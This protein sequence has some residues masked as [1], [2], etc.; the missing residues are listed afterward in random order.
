M[1][2]DA[3]SDFPGTILAISHDRYFINRFAERVMVM[4]E[5]GM[6]EYIGDFD[7]YLE[8]RDRPAPPPELPEGA[9][10]TSIARER[11]RDRQQSARLRELKAAVA[12]AEEAIAASERRVSELEGQ[13]ADPAVYGDQPRLVELTRAYQREQDGQEALYDALDRAEQA[14]AAEGG[15]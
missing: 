8:K 9:T 6:T 11:K 10:R 14:Y 1:L 7:D 12:K 13:L 15:E 2:E 4:S 3:L 5:N